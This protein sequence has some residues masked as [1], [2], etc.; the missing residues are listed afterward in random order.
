MAWFSDGDAQFKQFTQ[1]VCARVYG[2]QEFNE[3][4]MRYV[5]EAHLKN[6]REYFEG[7]PEDLL[8]MDICDGEGWEK[9]CPF[10]GLPVPGTPFAH[11]N[12]GSGQ[13]GGRS[14]A[15][16]VAQAT[17]EIARVIPADETFILVDEG[18]LASE[19][20]LETNAVPFLENAGRYWGRPEED[21]TAIRE[22]ERLRGQSA[23]FLVFISATFWWLEYYAGFHRYL[24]ANF[25]CI[26]ESECLVVFDLRT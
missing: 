18:T 8:I 14:W 2:T 7:R 1:F 6:V 22:L 17:T 20:T 5:Y 13:Q 25:R 3:D 23:K 12:K 9:L 10:L 24:R 15:D 19:S 11:V 21:Q 4:R 26:L 16:Q